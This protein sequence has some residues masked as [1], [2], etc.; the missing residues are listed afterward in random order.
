M[1]SISIT[2]FSSQKGKKKK[3]FFVTFI[4]NSGEIV[5]LIS[6]LLNNLTSLRI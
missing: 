5:L 4:K 2:P 6:I 3:Q 1:H